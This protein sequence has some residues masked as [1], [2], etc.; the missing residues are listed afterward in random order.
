MRAKFPKKLT[1]VHYGAACLRRPAARIGPITEE[2]EELARKMLVALEEHNGLGLAA[3][4]VGVEKQLAVLDLG[5]GPLVIIN[6]KIVKREGEEVM[7]EGCLS[8]PG[9]Y[10]EV[11]RAAKVVVEA[12]NL[13][14]RKVKIKAE[15]MFARAL[16]HEIDHLQGRLF[17]D[18]VREETLHWLVRGKE[19]NQADVEGVPLESEPLCQPTT[20]ED[21]LK[22]FLSRPTCQTK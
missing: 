18:L 1:V 10:G 21:A 3:P 16:Q 22:V 6:P 8:F 19:K 15:K 14:G 13:S 11:S 20:L 4:Q 17:V 9:L 5:E 12:L 2:I 7:V